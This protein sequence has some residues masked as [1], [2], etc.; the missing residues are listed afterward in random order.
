MLYCKFVLF[1]GWCESPSKQIFV[2]NRSRSNGTQAVNFLMFV[3]FIRKRRT[4][5]KTLVLKPYACMPNT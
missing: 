5:S 1:V 4:H 3:L 2:P